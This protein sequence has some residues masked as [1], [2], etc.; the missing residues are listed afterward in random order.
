MV[1]V[2]KPKF[3]TWK[4]VF[5]LLR[6]LFLFWSINRRFL[7]FLLIWRW[8][9]VT[10]SMLAVTLIGIS[11]ALKLILVLLLLRYRSLGL[12]ED[13]LPTFT[14]LGNHAC[15]LKQ[16]G[17]IWSSSR[18][19]LWLRAIASRCKTYTAVTLWT[20]CQKYYRHVQISHY[21]CRCSFYFQFYMLTCLLDSLLHLAK[22]HLHSFLHL[23]HHHRYCDFL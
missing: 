19:L 8:W 6:V 22:L 13:A 12:L 16:C 18:I 1:T 21:W 15:L 5:K 2:R 10:H 7:E 4:R 20:R 3:L 11:W 9:L 17:L 23:V 14:C